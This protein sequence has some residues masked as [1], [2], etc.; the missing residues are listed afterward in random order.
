MLLLPRFVPKVVLPHMFARAILAL[1]T[2]IFQVYLAVHE[3]RLCPGGLVL[4]NSLSE[5]A[6]AMKSRSW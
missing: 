3:M 2:S 1:I 5:G 4:Y 6:A